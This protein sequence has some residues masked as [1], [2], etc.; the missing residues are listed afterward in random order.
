MDLVPCSVF[1]A[2]GQSVLFPV[3]AAVFGASLL[4]LSVSAMEKLDRK[5]RKAAR[6]LLSFNS[7]CP[8]PCTLAELGWRKL[9]VE[10]EGERARQLGRLLASTNNHIIAILD[11]S[12]LFPFLYFAVD[13]PLA[14]PYSTTKES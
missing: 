10:L 12:A 11:A 13:V 5:Q 1:C 8:S 9:S 14:A 3:R 4:D 7:R 6:L 2:C